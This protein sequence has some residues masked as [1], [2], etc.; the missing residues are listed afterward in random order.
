ML[1]TLHI[2]DNSLPR[3]S[4]ACQVYRPTLS[5]FAPSI[6]QQTI[7]HIDVVATWKGLSISQANELCLWQYWFQKALEVIVEDALIAKLDAA[8]IP[9]DTV[10]SR[11]FLSLRNIVSLS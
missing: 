2:E 5:A 4:S 11:I 9:F 8:G 6:E 1:I 3:W 10:K 7:E